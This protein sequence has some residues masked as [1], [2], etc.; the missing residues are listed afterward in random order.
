[1]SDSTT[2][3]NT[4]GT[5]NPAPNPATKPKRTR[6]EI[7]LKYLTEYDLSDSLVLEARY[8]ERTA[9]LTERGWP[10]TR[11][12]AY[13]TL[14]NQLET[15]ALLAVGRVNSRKLNTEEK[16][17]AR[18]VMLD[19][20]HPILAGA[21]RTYRGKDNE[22]GR[23]AFYV[24][25]PVSISLER[26]LF[27]AG[28]ILLKLESQPD[29]ANPAVTLPAEVTLDGVIA[30]DIQTLQN[31]RDDYVEA[32]AA[33]NKTEKARRQAHTDVE[34][35][36]TQTRAERIDLQLAADQAYPHTAPNGVNNAIRAAFDIPTDR[37]ATE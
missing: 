37:P 21:K 33:K 31:R 6:G 4:G 10:P 34:T 14:G 24:N 19:A 30:S 32:G 25:E 26:L 11:I 15:A 36:F 27:I 29:P 17:V 13:E 5:P 8:P 9:L 16:K 12:T 18:K 3:D 7:N 20:F 2:P 22:A 28:E 1:M 35:L 23:S